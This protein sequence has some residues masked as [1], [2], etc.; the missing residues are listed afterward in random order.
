M[1]YAGILRFNPTFEGTP[2]AII[3][4][5]I[6]PGTAAFGN[7]QI[8]IAEQNGPERNRLIGILRDMGCEHL[9]ACES[10]DSVKEKIGRAVSDDHDGFS[11]DLIIIDQHLSPHIGRFIDDVRH[12]RYGRNPFV[13]L[14]LTTTSTD[15]RDITRLIRQ[16]ADD[17]VVKPISG[18][19][20]GERIEY[21]AVHRRPFIVTS[22]YVGPDR[23]LDDDRPS[24]VDQLAVPNTL[25][26]QL[27]GATASQ[28]DTN[29][30]IKD[31]VQAI[32]NARLEQHAQ[33]LGVLSH[34]V[35]EAHFDGGSDSAQKSQ[36]M[37][38]S[39]R[40]MLSLLRD[41][42]RIGSQV[43]NIAMI[44]LSRSLRQQIQG[45]A[46]HRDGLTEADIMLLKDLVEAV[47]MTIGVIA[48]PNP[49]IHGLA[50]TYQKHGQQPQPPA[51]PLVIPGKG[52]GSDDETSGGFF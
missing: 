13:S 43:K 9:H 11:P 6:G 24:T 31:A 17:V 48:L 30:T 7:A 19:L 4:S 22:D 26:D 46:R 47:K 29:T 8:L 41:I 34:L 51:G 36:P 37:G 5:P 2:V 38:T 20:L 32:V 12:G 49:D 23:R 14:I 27:S 45:I 3:S 44:E 16:G 42:Q 40:I 15:S 10:L 1:C 33:S 25:L 28:G 50:K 35:L 52:E 21:V 39:L 18:R